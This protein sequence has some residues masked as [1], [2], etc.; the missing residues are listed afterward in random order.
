MAQ[1][2]STERQRYWRELIGRQRSSGRSIAAFCR[3]T[4]VSVASFYEW[5]RK[6]RQQKPSARPSGKRTSFA[7]V[8]IMPAQ[9]ASSMDLDGRVEVILP[10]GVVLRIAAGCEE[11]TLQVV[12]TVL[13]TSLTK[14]ADGC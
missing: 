8:Q 11:R 3:E 4:G 12:W 13:A 7:P 10:E 9:T 1:T 2:G 6:L 5:K 14:G